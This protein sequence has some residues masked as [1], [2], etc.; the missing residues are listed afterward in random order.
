MARL[1]NV[2]GRFWRYTSHIASVCLLANVLMI[3]A[4]ILMRRFF[5]AICGSVPACISTMSA[6]AYPEMRKREYSPALAGS[7]IAAG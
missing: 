3:I 2:A 6:V 4:N 5:G 7:C 1:A